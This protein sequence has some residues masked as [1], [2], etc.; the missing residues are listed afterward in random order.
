MDIHQKTRRLIDEINRLGTDHHY[1]LTRWDKFANRWAFILGISECE[2]GDEN[3]YINFGS[4]EARCV[5]LELI[6]REHRGADPGEIVFK[7]TT[8]QS[9]TAQL[10]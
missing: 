8:R 9:G 4:P 7:V 10:T 1:T 3:R 2:Y 5:A 6:V